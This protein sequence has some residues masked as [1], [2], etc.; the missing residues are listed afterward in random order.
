MKVAIYKEMDVL[1]KNIGFLASLGTNGVIVG[2]FGTVI[3]IMGSFRSIAFSQ[4]INI[5]TI[6]P[7]IAEALFATAVGLVAAIP[8]ALFY[9]KITV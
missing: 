9:N 8:A 5:T 6:A 3:G 7:G 2:L 1:E 4:N